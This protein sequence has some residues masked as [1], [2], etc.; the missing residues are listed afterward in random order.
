MCLQ[1]ISLL[2]SVVAA[3]GGHWFTCLVLTLNYT[4]H[5]DIHDPTPPRH[6][7]S[8]PNKTVLEFSPQVS[9]NPAHQ[10]PPLSI[11]LPWKVHMPSLLQSEDY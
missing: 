2:P 9:H 6:T 8:M 1:S 11:T 7:N 3:K 10:H 4:P 5:F